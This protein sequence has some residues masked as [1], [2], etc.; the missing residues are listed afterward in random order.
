MLYKILKSVLRVIL[1]PL[2]RVK[3]IHGERL[4]ADDKLVVYANHTTMMDPVL[5]HLIIKNKKPYFL[6]KKELFDH[7]LFG[8]LLT[9]LGAMPVNRSTA[10][11][12]VLKN[13]FQLLHQGNTLCIFPEGTRSKSGELQAFQPGVAVI[14]ARTNSPLLPVYIS[15]PRIFRRTWIVVGER[16][17]VRDLPNL[18]LTDPESVR[19]VVQMMQSKILELRAQAEKLCQK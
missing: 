14:A 18:K 6:A 10:D 9:W 11:L 5:I 13:A 16:F 12:L 4:Q 3:T 19:D 7:K 2:Y 1:L 17:N 15:R 8:R